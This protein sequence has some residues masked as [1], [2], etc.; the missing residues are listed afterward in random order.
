MEEARNLFCVFDRELQ[1]EIVVQ[2]LLGKFLVKIFVVLEQI[3]NDVSGHVA[4][5][6]YEDRGIYCSLN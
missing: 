1:M 4:D 2:G 3:G 5:G 6:R